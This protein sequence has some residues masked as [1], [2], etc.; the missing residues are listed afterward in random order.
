VFVLTFLTADLTNSGNGLLSFLLTPE[1][2]N[3]LLYESALNSTSEDV[4]IASTN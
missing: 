1:Y 2:L 4:L 3:N